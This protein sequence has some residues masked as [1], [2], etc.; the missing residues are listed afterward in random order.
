MDCGGMSP[1]GEA[2]HWQL[3]ELEV[4]RVKGIIFGRDGFELSTSGLK[5]SGARA[6]LMLLTVS[7]AAANRVWAIRQPSATQPISERM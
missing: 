7:I 2:H 6:L 3:L 1:N 4:Y 5:V